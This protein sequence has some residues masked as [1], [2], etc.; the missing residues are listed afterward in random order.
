[1]KRKALS[2]VLLLILAFAL[3]SGCASA[4]QPSET[5]ETPAEATVQETTATP[6]PT[7]ETAAEVPE[8]TEEMMEED[9][10]A[11]EPRVMVVVFSGTGHTRRI[12][13]VIADGLGTE[14]KEIVPAEPYTEEDLN[15][16]DRST[17]ATVEQNDP[18]ARPEIA[19]AIDGLKDCDILFLGYPIWWG[20]EPRILDTFVETY[21]LSGIT[22]A[23]F[24]TSGSSGIGISVRQLSGL[25]DGADWMEGRRFET[26]ATEVEIN[27]WAA[28]MLAAAER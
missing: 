8:E 18:A 5:A 2:S 9:Q 3:L 10:T 6:V 22:V 26:D 19:E 20:Q 1:M 23:P 21:D 15:Y 11:A 13:K 28:E 12:A 25:A 14:L 17:R 16:N 24:C 27:N 4:P 7:A